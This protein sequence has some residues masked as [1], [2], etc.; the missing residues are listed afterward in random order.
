MKFRPP[1]IRAGWAASFIDPELTIFVQM[2]LSSQNIDNIRNFFSARPVKKAYI[3]GSY[4]RN[5]AD[6]HSD[7]DILV[8]LDH[9]KPIGMKFFSYKDEL[10]LILK[11]KVDL[12]TYD[13]LSKYI[14]PII[15]KDKILIYER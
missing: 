7:I 8:E 12:V 11:K 6:E 14:K 2:N 1:T 10:E 15:D 4:S 5:E 9:T 3:F 13:G